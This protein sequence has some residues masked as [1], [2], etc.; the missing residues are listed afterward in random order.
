MLLLTTSRYIS[1]K[2]YPEARILNELTRCVKLAEKRTIKFW[3]L[4]TQ[5]LSTYFLWNPRC[6]YNC[7]LGGDREVI[8]SSFSFFYSTILVHS[9]PPF[10]VIIGHNNLLNFFK[11]SFF[12]SQSGS[13]CLIFFILWSIYLLGNPILV[14]SMRSGS[15][16]L[17]TQL[18]LQIG[19]CNLLIFCVKINHL[20]CFSLMVYFNTS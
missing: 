19:Q 14:C 2:M 3:K 16:R 1:S 11:W 6:W 5:S 18:Y 8:S 17:I 10:L 12:W 15:I 7:F 13:L 4:Q 9:F 20:S